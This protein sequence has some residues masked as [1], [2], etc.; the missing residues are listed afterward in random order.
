M[1]LVDVSDRHL[2]VKYFLLRPSKA[3]LKSGFV[4]IDAEKWLI[5]RSAESKFYEDSEMDVLFAQPSQV[6]SQYTFK[7]FRT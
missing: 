5:Y 7:I 2:H 3:F 4:E 1:N 6:A